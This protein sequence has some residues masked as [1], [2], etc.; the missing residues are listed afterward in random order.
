LKSSDPTNNQQIFC[1]EI[2]SQKEFNEVEGEEK[3]RV[4]TSNSFAALEDFSAKGDINRA[5]YTARENIKISVKEN[6][7]YNKLKKHEPWFREWSANYY[8][9]ER[10]PNFS[11]HSSQA[12]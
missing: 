12:K 4:E 8:T 1:R 7:G 10:K 11:G 2:H 3:Y 5:C 6:P 9:F